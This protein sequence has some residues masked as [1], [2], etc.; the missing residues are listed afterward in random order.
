MFAVDPE[1]IQ[2]SVENETLILSGTRAT[3]EVPE[4]ARLRRRE[5][6]MGDFTRTLELPFRIDPD[7]VEATVSNGVLQIVLPRLPEEKPK[8]IAVNSA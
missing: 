2:L 5:R 1:D 8:K 6:S 7:G 4:N 3:E